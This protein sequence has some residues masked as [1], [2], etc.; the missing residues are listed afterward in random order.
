MALRLTA[1]TLTAALAAAPVLAADPT[2]LDRMRTAHTL[3]RI[4]LDSGDGL[5]VIAAARL[6]KGVTATPAA[7]APEGGAALEGEP[8]GWR[9]MLDDAAPLIAGDPLLI[10]L[11]GDVAA[12]TDKGV[13]TGP[14]YSIVEIRAGGRDKYAGV[15]F[16]GGQ[17]AEI[18]VEGAPGTDLNLLVHDDRGRLVCSDTDISAIAYC[19]WNPAS[20][21]QFAITVV[22]DGGNGGRYSMMTN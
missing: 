15:P 8:L 20:D 6:R 2:P 13:M 9:Q 18:Y 4:G 22:N 3:Y 19:G 10:G 1:L 14:V 16:A 17:Y 7:R 12:E 21:G 11:A 5:L